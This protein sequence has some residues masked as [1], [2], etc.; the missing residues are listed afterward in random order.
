MGGIDSDQAGRRIQN[1]QQVMEFLTLDLGE[2]YNCVIVEAGLQST[3]QLFAI[4]EWRTN[5][6]GS[7]RNEG[8][9]NILD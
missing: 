5:P 6:I 2:I 4:R 9:L 1:P 3:Y 7:H 8:T